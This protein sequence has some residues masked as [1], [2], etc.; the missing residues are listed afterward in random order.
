MTNEIINLKWLAYETNIGPSLQE[1]REN[2]D[3][4][5]VTLVCK[6][7]SSQAHKVV[8]GSSSPFFLH[9]LR[10]SPHPH[11]LIYLRGVQHKQIQLLLNFIYNGKVDVTQSDLDSLLAVPEDLEIKGLT[12]Q[13]K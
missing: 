9:L 12:Y 6:D 1:I 5:D 10:S 7:G 3:F 8:L 11:P 4:F 13:L 2:E